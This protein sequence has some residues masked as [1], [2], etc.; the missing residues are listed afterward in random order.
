MNK[1]LFKM[2]WKCCAICQEDNYVLLDTHRIVEGREYSE[3]NCI[4]LC[5]RCHRKHHM[6]QINIKEKRYT[7]NGYVLIYEENG[8]DNIIQL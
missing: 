5:C 3:G 6:G 1:R 2:R 7:T 8:E 4:A